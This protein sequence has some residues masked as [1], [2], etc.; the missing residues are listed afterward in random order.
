MPRLAKE[1]S[2]IEVKRL[3]HS[4]GRGSDMTA[5]GGV[6]GLYMQLLPTGG[7]TWVLRTK[8]GLKSRDIGLG[9]YPEVSLAMARERAREAKDKIRQGVDPVE[10]R[11]AARAAL[12]AAHRRGLTFG[13][14]IGKYAEAKLTNVGD[15]D[16]WVSSL[17]RYARPHVGDMLVQDIA[18]QD[19]LRVLEPIWTSKTDTATRVRARMEAVLS[20]ATV[21]G[22]RTGDNPARWGG[23]LKELLPVPS[24]VAKGSN[25]PALALADAPAWF[26]DL[27]KREGM[28]SRAL[29]FLALTAARSGEVRGA[30]WDE[31]DLKAGLW[32][33]PAARMK[34]E[35]EHRV[36]LPA[37][38]VKLLEA[39]P[40]FEGN[41]L[42]F[43]AARGG[44][45]SDMTLSATMKRMHEA[46][47]EAER[48]GWLD[49]RNG[50][51]AVPH[52]LRSTFRD[53]A[54]ETGQP[55]DMAE[56]ALAHN[57][58]SDVERAYRRSD[59]VERRRAMMA[60]WAKFLG[61]V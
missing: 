6:S 3:K 54:A 15:R 18:V 2:A 20:W 48:K 50:R 55:R 24:K 10:E 12:I 57:T 53:W 28:G 1:L 30:T 38:A 8:V 16:R 35:R 19:V 22:H 27:R 13:D 44:Q 21:A 14:A 4:G 45:L 5:V 7:R 43:P 46:E 51:P 29:E 36:P 39:L 17:E 60:E 9:G 11:K 40:R 59:M 42:V 34:M 32:V 31:I 33:I 49:S 26:A 37:A 47:V 58:G 23:N 56:I 61:A 52:G 41:P 25:Q